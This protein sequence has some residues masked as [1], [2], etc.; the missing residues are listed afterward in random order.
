ME[1]TYKQPLYCVIY[2]YDYEHRGDMRN[3]LNAL[4]RC[5]ISDYHFTN[6]GYGNAAEITF[7][8][9]YADRK[10]VVD[11]MSQYHIEVSAI[12][13]WE[14]GS[15]TEQ[16]KQ[17][18]RKEY[19]TSGE[20]ESLTIEQLKQGF[21]IEFCLR[22]YCSV[23]ERDNNK[24]K[25]DISLLADE[26]KSSSI[27]GSR[28]SLE[29]FLSGFVNILDVLANEEKYINLMQQ[30]KILVY[31][32]DNPKFFGYRAEYNYLNFPRFLQIV[33]ELYIVK[34]LRDKIS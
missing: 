2:V 17:Y 29:V 18:N 28:T 26:M 27:Y 24:L 3:H 11:I 19:R 9:E 8:I 12:N 16:I 31:C 25:E 6:N 13:E 5:G 20:L 15:F 7:T 33:K 34:G 14:Y 21:T 22:E 1:K 30:N 10:Q 32:L 4:S 23:Y